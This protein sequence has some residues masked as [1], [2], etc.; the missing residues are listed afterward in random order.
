MLVDSRDD[1]DASAARR[2][3]EIV[4][5]LLIQETAGVDADCESETVVDV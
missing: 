5:N 1:E 2:D 4:R 3:E